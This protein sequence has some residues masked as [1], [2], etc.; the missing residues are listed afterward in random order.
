MSGLVRVRT[1]R[2]G[3]PVLSGDG[4]SRMLNLGGIN[5]SWQTLIMINLCPCAC[6][7]A[8]VSA[9]R[10]QKEALAA[11]RMRSRAHLTTRGARRYGV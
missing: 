10:V 3:A 1:V 6:A 2:G 9:L 11:T 4:Y 5:I 7:L 8:P